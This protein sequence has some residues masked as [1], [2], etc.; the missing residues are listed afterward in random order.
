MDSAPSSSPQSRLPDDE[1]LSVG[2]VEPRSVFVGRD[3]EMSELLVGLEEALAG[4]GRLFLLAGEPGIGKSRLA[5]ELAIK[6]K[7]IGA[8][9]DW[10][11]CW[12]AGGAPAYWPWV[13]L[14]RSYLRNTDPESL[15]SQMG[16]GAADIAQMLPEVEQLLP[17]LSPPPAVDPE[18]ARFRLFDATA[19]F[20][21][22][23]ARAQPRVLVLDDFH[24]ADTPSLLLLQFLAGQLADTRILVVVTYRDTELSR[25]HPLAAALAELVRHQVTSRLQ[26]AGLREADVRQLIKLTTGQTPPDSVVSEVHRET[27]GNPLFVGEVV[28]LLA[29]EGNL[30]RPEEVTSRRLGIPQGVREVI[31]RRL[32]QLS[33][34][35]SNVLALAAVFG[36]EF[37][38]DALK[39][40]AERSG[41]ELLQILDDPAVARV[42]TDVPG[43]PGRLRFSH[44]LV[45]DALYDELP[46]TRRLRLHRQSGEALEALYANDPESHLAE[47]AHHF[48]EAAPTGVIGK[49]VDYARRAADRAV[50][51]L[52]YEEAV[53]LYRMALQA[54][55]PVEPSDE[56]THCQLLLGLGDA[57]A[58]AGDEPGSKGSFLAAAE[59]A[60]RLGD[61]ENLAQAALGYAG[62]FVWARAGKDRHIVPL[63]EEALAALGVKDSPLRV[64]MMARL[65]G[66][67]RDQL[68]R[69]PRGSLSAEAVEM[70]RRIG[71]PATL[72][73]ALDGRCAVLLWPE[74][75]EERVALTTELVRVADGVGNLE[76]VVQGHYY[77]LMAFLELGDLHAVNSEL[78]V[79]EG[80]A[81]E[82]KQ[83]PQLW[84]VDV[85][86]ATLA[87]FKGR[88]EDAEQL[89]PKALAIGEQAQRSDAVL[90]YRVQSFT[91]A[92][93]RGKLDEVEPLIRQ[94]VDEYSARPMF[95]CMLALLVAE[96]G[97]TDEAQLALGSLAADDF[98]S[99]PP[100]NEWI[101]SMSMLA[102]VA[103]LVGDAERARTMYSLLLQ[104]A[105]YNGS[106]ADYISTG[107]VS[108]YLGLLASTMG[109]PDVADRHFDDALKMNER[110]GAAP[111][112]AH[113]RFD[114]ARMLLTR[115][116]PGDRERAGE[117]V[118][119][120]LE[121]CRELG[122]VV[123]E[124][125]TSLL[126]EEAVGAAAYV[127]TETEGGPHAAHPS[128]FRRDG[129]YWTVA[130]EGEAFRLRDLK[131][132]RYVARLLAEPGRE[133]H[134]LDLV[135]TESRPDAMERGAEPTLE[136]SGL[137]DA[138]AVLDPQAKA[139]YRSRLAELEEEIDEARRFGDAERAARA[140]EE[141]EFIAREIARAVGLGGRDRRAAS[142]SERA[143]VS[144]TRA[145][146][147]ALARVR[148]HSPALGRHLDRTIRT[149]TFC[150]Y[151]P[152]PRARIDWR[153]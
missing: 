63:L 56:R 21:G 107:A 37:D 105:A 6:A 34:D 123:L 19:T 113:T 132:L 68:P 49:A 134:V 103:E 74:N 122:M 91:L 24:V 48:F 102:E 137:G 12:E 28:R 39:R 119:A 14:L 45:R 66:A 126:L 120:A 87:L 145:I 135:A 117:L 118:A 97:R 64:R 104:Y 98:A 73:Y 108:R 16:P 152:D 69:E 140:D 58:K 75:P 116:L 33:E 13:Q 11:R 146:R 92:R 115:D 129:E 29:A 17:D 40:V 35:H 2:R 110:M 61:A 44:A 32:S 111:W 51:L 7:E 36:R 47:L 142:S 151:A 5:D 93:H 15:S 31:A 77:R 76:K 82:L 20:L 133:F 41:D 65:A 99:L 153:L 22:N 52:A 139:A 149:G 130:F 101:F 95:R 114:H 94:S 62:R 89:I 80:L 18:A 8:R 10:G 67:L 60:R 30:D 109:R 83:R 127:Q 57:Q 90:S 112:V 59:I 79:I 50:R 78:D 150:S 4:R 96:L 143:R 124:K 125:R 136:S 71:D 121:S 27:E 1:P 72:A 23:A 141:R 46:P 148:E 55:D 26:L 54:L 53:R 81:K 70:A 128:M 86:R 144:V 25:D 85:T 88:L 42:F 147:A 9:V 131:G 3:R 38:L 138:G 106:T 43:V 84:L 100:T